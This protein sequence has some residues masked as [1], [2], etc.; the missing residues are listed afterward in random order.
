M[1]HSISLV[2]V[3]KEESGTATDLRPGLNVRVAQKVNNAE[4]QELK[5]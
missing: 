1:Q 5:R 2:N 3:E 4:I